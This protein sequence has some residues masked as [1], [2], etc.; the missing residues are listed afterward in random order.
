M[1]Y[2]VNSAGIARDSLLIAHA[3][4]DIESVIATNLMGTIWLNKAVAK[5][6]MRR[7]RGKG[8]C[9]SLSSSSKSMD[10]SHV[11]AYTYIPTYLHSPYQHP[12]DGHIG[13]F[14]R[15]NPKVQ[16]FSM[17]VFM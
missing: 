8:L 4:Q 11:L 1:D 6:M 10:F 7:K 12:L 17:L 2:M 16:T 5:G 13:R 9:L 15:F 3:S 14:G